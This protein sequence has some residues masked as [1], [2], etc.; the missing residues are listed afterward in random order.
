MTLHTTTKPTVEPPSLSGNDR[1]PDSAAGPGSI[2]D[3]D[4]AA[5]PHSLALRAAT[6]VLS[7][8]YDGRPM[9]ET[10]E[11][12]D[13][14]ARH[15][16]SLKDQDSDVLLESL[17]S[18]LLV[19]EACFQRL[20]VDALKAEHPDHRAALMRIALHAQGSYT[21][22]AAVLSLVRA[23]GAVAVAVDE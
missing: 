2:P 6:N 15:N 12:I 9:S 8:I 22:T 1:T 23:R 16:Q 21:R 19:L 3:S 14:L 17:A 13:T 18:Q 7:L 4:S 11:Q 20:V 10:R 5:K